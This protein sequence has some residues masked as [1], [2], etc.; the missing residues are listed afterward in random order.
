MQSQSAFTE[1]IEVKK[2][3]SVVIMHLSNFEA[4]KLRRT[5]IKSFGTETVFEQVHNWNIKLLSYRWL[6]LLIV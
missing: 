2:S 1:A 5:W 3:K 6:I 4:K